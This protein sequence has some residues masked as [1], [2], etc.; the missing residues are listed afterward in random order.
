MNIVGAWL[1]HKIQGQ[2]PGKLRVPKWKGMA[3]SLR[4]GQIQNLIIY[5]HKT[6]F[7]Y[8]QIIIFYYK[9]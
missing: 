1:Q 9:N 7:V 2:R 5:Y 3:T 6:C 8:F 4:R